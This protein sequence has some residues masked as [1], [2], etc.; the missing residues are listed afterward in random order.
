MKQSKIEPLQ[1]YLTHYLTRNMFEDMMKHMEHFLI[2]FYVFRALIANISMW[3][4]IDI[5]VFAF[6]PS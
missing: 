2:I 5:S 3:S 6:K 4:K 1:W